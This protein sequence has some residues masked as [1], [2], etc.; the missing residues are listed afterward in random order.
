MQDDSDLWNEHRTY[1]LLF[2]QLPEAVILVDDVGRL[3]L[4]NRTARDSRAYLVDL[5]KNDDA[6][7]TELVQL[8]ADVR[9]LGEASA[10]VRLR[11]REGRLRHIALHGRRIAPDRAQIVL[12]DVTEHRELEA[13]LAHMRRVE[14]LGLL[15]ASVVHDFNNKLTPIV[16]LSAV[17]SNELGVETSNGALAKEIRM[18]AERAAGLVRQVLSFA[19]RTHE[20]GSRVNISTVVSEMC[21]L[22]ERVV[23]DDV[24]ISVVRNDG[25]AEVKVHRDQLEQVI[26][27]LAANARDAMPRGGRLTVTASHVTLGSNEAVANECPRAGAYI[28]LAITDT[29]IGMSKETRER[30]FERFFTTKAPGQGSGLGLATAH[31]FAR[32]SGG[33]IAVHS[34]P[35]RGTTVTLY[36]PRRDGTMA[37]PLPPSTEELP[38]G[39]ETVLVVEDDDG[40]RGVVHAVLEEQGYN[41]IST[42]SPDA[43]L[44]MVVR[45]AP[46][47]DLLLADVVMPGISGPALAH[48]L[49]SA[50]LQMKVL[51]MSGHGEDEIRTHG[52]DG[53]LSPILRKA[54]SPTDLACKVREVL[55][56]HE[57]Q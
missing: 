48:K 52:L 43:A 35:G 36:L 13:E 56:A 19:R 15:T 17:L 45:D 27:N 29:G 40:V 50:G 8:L 26:L 55:D 18:T 32:Q 14:S 6:G 9:A 7:R 53:E 30:V 4:A 46:P 12:R 21:G 1:R 34:E 25:D 33:C 57:T 28:A 16:C 31:R 47:I 11:D 44:D 42:R 49:E 39:N 2:E 51:F 23:G 20:H 24:E 3:L 38:R 37:S 10:E 22:I 5:L 41:V 54:F